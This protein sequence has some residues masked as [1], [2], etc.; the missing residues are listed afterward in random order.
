M[1]RDAIMRLC[2]SWIESQEKQGFFFG[3]T[4]TMNHKFDRRVSPEECATSAQYPYVCGAN[5]MMRVNNKT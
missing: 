3:G 5:I 4:D 1:E 2:S